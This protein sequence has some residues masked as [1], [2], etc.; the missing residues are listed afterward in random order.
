MHFKMIE[1]RNSLKRNCF[2]IRERF[3]YSGISVIFYEICD[4]RAAVSLQCAMNSAQNPAFETPQ[5]GEHTC[6]IIRL[7]YFHHPI[8]RRF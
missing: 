1:L 6:S 7:Q 5:K 3:Y 4:H 8:A 2:I